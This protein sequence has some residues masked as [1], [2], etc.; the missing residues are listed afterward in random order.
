MARPSKAA[1]LKAMVGRRVKLL[2]EMRTKGGN[3]FPE[4]CVMVV[5]SWW[6][7]GVT[8]TDANNTDRLIRLNL[9][10][11]PHRGFSNKPFVLL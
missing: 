5:S 8:L 4:D 11:S 7:S 6:R 1:D 9:V 10:W 3:V 2:H